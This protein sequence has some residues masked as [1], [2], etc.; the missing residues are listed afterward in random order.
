MRPLFGL[1][2]AVKSALVGLLLGRRRNWDYPDTLGDMS[3]GVQAPRS[4]R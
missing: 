1:N 4:P 3:L 2:L